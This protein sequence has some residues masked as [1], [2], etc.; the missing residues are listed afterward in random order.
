MS[1][2]LSVK[3]L[4]M[5]VHSNLVPR[6]S[7][8]LQ[9]GFTLRARVGCS[10]KTLLCDQLGM[11]PEYLEERVQTIFLDGKPIDDASSATLK[12]GSTL[13]LS[14][15]LPGLAGATLRRGGYY[16]SLRSQISHRD[17]RIS[18]PSH[19]GTI[20]LKLFNL[21][22]KELGPTFLTHGIW[23]NGDNLLKFF[24]DQPEDFWEDCQVAEVDGE[25][26][27]PEKLR[28]MTWE[29]RDVFLRVSIN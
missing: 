12:P 24:R 7:L 4:S 11:S 23:I 21:T 6:F 26:I 28:E 3:K 16:A 8:F 5:I 14:A 27:I 20:F 19:E 29:E 13:A 18:E 15:A 1:A 17:E 9:Q 22:L 2:I 25:T 10:I